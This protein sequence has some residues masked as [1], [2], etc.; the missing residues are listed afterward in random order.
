M[1]FDFK[2]IISIVPAVLSIVKPIR[3]KNG[4]KLL[5]AI[6]KGLKVSVPAGGTALVAL[7]SGA[8]QAPLV[9]GSV[10]IPAWVI[11]FI[12]TQG[13]SMVQGFIKHRK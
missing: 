8:D 3:T 11:V 13:I 12:A 9:I 10:S 6:K 4:F 7:P 1:K 5:P 2:K